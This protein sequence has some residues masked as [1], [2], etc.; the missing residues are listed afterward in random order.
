MRRHAART[1]AVRRGAALALALLVAAAAGCSPN[2]T[3]TPP[4]MTGSSSPPTAS[5]STGPSGTPGPTSSVAIDPSLLAVLPESVDGLPVTESPEAEA[6]SVADPQLEAVASA[7]AAGI[8]VEASTGEFA[9]AVVVRLL[10]GAMNDD[11]FRDWRDSYDEGAC[12][13]A[14]GVS[15]HAETEIGGRTVYIGTCAGGLRTYHVWLEAQD[16]LVSVSAVGERR[17]GEHLVGNLRP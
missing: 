7:L 17:L 11:T 2:T 13:Q 1:V 15:G 16:L 8:A 4:S 14:D 6:A 10:P 12:S 5:P 3:A 9:F